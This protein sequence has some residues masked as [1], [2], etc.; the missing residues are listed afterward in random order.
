MRT[1]LLGLAGFLILMGHVG[2]RDPEPEPKAASADTG[3]ADMPG[4]PGMKMAESGAIS[5]S[6][7]VS[8]TAAQVTT[9]KIVWEMDYYD[10][11]HAGGARKNRIA[12]QILTL[13][14][15]D[16][17]LYYESDGSH[18][19]GDWNSEPPHDPEGYGIRVLKV[20]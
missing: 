18:S 3:M 16:Y 12:V 6:A 9:G 2:C 20:E 1:P 19:F 17:R 10:T 5:D 11:D 8:M 13:P 14:K 7:S 15:G 4:M